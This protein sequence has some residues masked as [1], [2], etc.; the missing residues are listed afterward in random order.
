MF[1][2]LLFFSLQLCFVHLALA[3]AGFNRGWAIGRSGAWVGVW[4]CGWAVQVRGRRCAP[5]VREL[6]EVG[7]VEVE[8]LRQPLHQVQALVVGEG[9]VERARHNTEQVGVRLT[10]T[11]PLKRL[12]FLFYS[13]AF[14]LSLWVELPHF[15]QPQTE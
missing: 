2:L 3:L 8:P 14:S 4:V 15:L 12:S 7:G 6:S 10:H 11:R 9:A 1:F 5:Y 13:F